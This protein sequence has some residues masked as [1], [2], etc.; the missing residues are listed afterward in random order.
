[1]I[2]FSTFVDRYEMDGLRNDIFC[3]QFSPDG[4][5]LATGT[6]DGKINV[7]SFNISFSTDLMPLWLDMG[8]R[9]KANESKIQTYRHYQ[10]HCLCSQRLFSRRW[11]R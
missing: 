8:H 4:Q 6:D 9:S 10:R 1:M 2:A 5:L 11:I 7:R 3:L